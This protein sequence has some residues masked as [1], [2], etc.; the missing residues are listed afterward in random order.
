M[1]WR[2]TSE[3]PLP[4]P[5]PI[6][7]ID[8]YMRHQGDELTNKGMKENLNPLEPAGKSLGAALTGAAPTTSE[9]STI[10]LPTKVPHILKV[11]QY[12][13][14]HFPGLVIYHSVSWRNVIFPNLPWDGEASVIGY[15]V[16]EGR[17]FL[18]LHFWQLLRVSNYSYFTKSR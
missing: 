6:Q 11:W 14:H 1:A 2:R 4:G 15:P 13:I 17:T 12:M 10:L 5:M 16:G 3:K 9:W 7:F 18:G 8:A